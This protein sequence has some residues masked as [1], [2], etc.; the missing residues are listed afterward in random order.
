MT[1]KLIEDM[2]AKEREQQRLR[3]RDYQRRRTGY[4]GNRNRCTECDGI[5]HNART[6]AEAMKCK[7]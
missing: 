6:C 5:G 2:S 3:A 1:G 7:K 4:T